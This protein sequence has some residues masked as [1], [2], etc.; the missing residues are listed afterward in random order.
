MT[1]PV[2]WRKSS[3]SGGTA[4]SDCV[5][6]AGLPDAIGIRDGK[7]PGGGHLTLPAAAFRTLLITIK[8]A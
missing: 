4:N 5:E 1:V 3:H 6:V 7:N 8:H 2:V